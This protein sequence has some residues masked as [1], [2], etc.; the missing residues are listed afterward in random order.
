MKSHKT[1]LALTFLLAHIEKHRSLLTEIL[2]DICAVEAQDIPKTGKIPRI[3]VLLASLLE[4]YYTCC[5]TIF[6]RISQFFE[7]NLMPERW[8]RDLLERMTLQ[9]GE[10]RPRILS[11]QTYQDL[12]ELMRFRHKRY[13]FARAYDWDRLNELVTRV[14]RLHPML[15]QELDTFLEFLQNLGK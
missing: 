9:A 12:L 14:N 4:N 5:E 2:A 13:Y 6:I 10:I 15:N 8:H 1:E 11:D 7:N 3:T